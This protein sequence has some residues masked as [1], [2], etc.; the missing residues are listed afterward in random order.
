MALLIQNAA[1][2]TRFRQAGLDDLKLSLTMGLA[3]APGAIIGAIAAVEIPG[4]WFKRI[5]AV[6][7]IAVLLLTLRKPKTQAQWH[8]E[9]PGLWAH[10][11][12]AGI[13]LYGGFV[14]AGIGFIIMAVLRGILHLDLV[15][16]NVH[17]VALVFVYTLP[18]LGIFA[19]ADKVVWGAGLALA[20]GNA[21]G[22]WLAAN[23][24][25]KRG[26]GPVRVVFAVA[27]VAMAIK[28]LVAP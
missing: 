13:G 21:L 17:K 23:V 4:L 26:E 27:V 16:I 6:V 14:Q 1:A 5:L 9:K 20:A 19:L 2:M 8:L 28:L 3:A 22:G 24:Q 7:M 25:S 15:R 10:L 11:A 18:V 12:A